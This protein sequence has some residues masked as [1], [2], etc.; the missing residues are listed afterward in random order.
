MNIND[1]KTDSAYDI[2]PVLL[3][4][5]SGKKVLKHATFK[6]SSSSYNMQNINSIPS[7]N[8]DYLNM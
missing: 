2:T 4:S 1:P 6:R 7:F 8:E 3:E 5:G